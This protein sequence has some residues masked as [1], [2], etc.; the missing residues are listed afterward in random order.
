MISDSQHS[1]RKQQSKQF[2]RILK[3]KVIFQIESIAQNE[4]DAT[5]SR[6]GDE[7]HRF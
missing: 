1:V 6:D 4:A 7:S 5:C 2:V 3:R